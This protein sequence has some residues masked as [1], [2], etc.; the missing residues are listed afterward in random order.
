MSAL[1]SR[2]RRAKK[3]PAARSKQLRPLLTWLLYRYQLTRFTP[4][5]ASEA[6]TARC[7]LRVEGKEDGQA[8]ATHVAGSARSGGQKGTF[9][10]VVVVNAC[11]AHL[12]GLVRWRGVG[13]GSKIWQSWCSGGGR[14]AHDG[15][16]HVRSAECRE[17]C[18]RLP[19]EEVR[20]VVQQH[21]EAVESCPGGHE[22]RVRGIRESLQV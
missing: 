1:Q 18:D 16:R 19:R 10:I 15:N 11:T 6:S 17:H 9:R 13:T 2:R 14:E 21:P 3:Y 4:A 8:Q 20:V 7:R 5:P 12:V 22:Q